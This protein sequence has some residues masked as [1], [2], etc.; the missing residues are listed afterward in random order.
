MISFL[1]LR[2]GPGRGE[3]L[4]PGAVC[5][6]AGCQLRLYGLPQ[7]DAEGD[8][9]SR[10]LRRA[11]YHLSARRHGTLPPTLLF[12]LP[13]PTQ[14]CDSVCMF[15]KTSGPD[16]TYKWDVRSFS[17]FFVQG[18]EGW[19]AV[20]LS[21]PVFSTSTLYCDHSPPTQGIGTQHP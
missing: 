6:G 3:P 7:C 8:S 2:P 12:P 19:F 1:R 21:V 4:Q 17:S 9:G 11:P 14:V 5:G 10:S 15:S 13:R 16:F 20:P 18:T